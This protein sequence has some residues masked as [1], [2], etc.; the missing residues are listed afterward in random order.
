MRSATQTCLAAATLLCA[1]AT[2]CGLVDPQEQKGSLSCAALPLPG[3]DLDSPFTIE[4]DFVAHDDCE[5]VL[6]LRVQHGGKGI[7]VSDGFE[8]HVSDLASLQAGLEDGP[9]TVQLPD[10]GVSLS[11]FLGQSCPQ[12]FEPLA[13]GPGSL[14][15]EA[16]D[17]DEGGRVR[18]DGQFDILDTR[19]GQTL[20]AGA[21]V[22]VD[23]E[24]TTYAPHTSFVYCP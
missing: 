4:A 8:I 23:S 22:S 24:I 18:L 15:F 17:L 3:C 12:S 6:F 7:G 13:A 14:T 16:L 5:N 20:C 2:S 19:T 1:S 21:T 11:L 9:V 10:E